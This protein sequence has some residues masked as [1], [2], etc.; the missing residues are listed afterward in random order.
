MKTYTQRPT[1]VRRREGGAN[2]SGMDWVSNFLG[3][4][5]AQLQNSR[6]RLSCCLAKSTSEAELRLPS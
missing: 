1:T 4:G 6:P 3:P 2:S 5:V